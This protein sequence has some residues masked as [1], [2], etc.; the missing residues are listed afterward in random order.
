M[1]PGHGTRLRFGPHPRRWRSI[2]TAR[3]HRPPCR[4]WRW[5]RASLAACPPTSRRCGPCW[6]T[7]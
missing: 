3:G 1:E 7:S 6:L 5:R 4:H 2:A